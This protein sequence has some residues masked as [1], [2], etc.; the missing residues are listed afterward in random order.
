MQKMNEIKEAI[1]RAIPKIANRLESELKLVCPVDKGFL[2]WSIN[3][4]AD[5]MTLTISMLDYGYYV[6]F[7]RPP[8]LSK[9]KK[10]KG[11]KIKTKGQRPNPFIRNTIRNKFAKIIQEEIT[12]SFSI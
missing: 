3:V 8:R 11:K 5:G 9:S 4:V 12:R 1:E 7:G 2:R 6:E 10:N